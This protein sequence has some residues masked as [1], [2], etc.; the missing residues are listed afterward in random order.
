MPVLN[1]GDGT[2]E[3]PTQALLDFFTISWFFPYLLDNELGQVRT[4]TRDLPVMPVAWRSLAVLRCCGWFSRCVLGVSVTSG[5]AAQS[6]RWS[7]CSPDT[8]S[9]SDTLHL[10][11]NQ[12][13]VL[14][15]SAGQPC[16]VCPHTFHRQMVWRC[17]T[18]CSR[19]SSTCSASTYV[20]HLPACLPACHAA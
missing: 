18:S 12:P 5:T 10:V 20:S 1:A 17:P 19:R 4:H 6:T 15:G 14:T 2:G 7:S 8:M 16:G 13:P 3:H 9:T 11:R